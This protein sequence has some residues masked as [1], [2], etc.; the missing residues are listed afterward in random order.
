ML[1]VNSKETDIQIKII[2]TQEHNHKIFL[3]NKNDTL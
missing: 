1:I 2:N 3:K